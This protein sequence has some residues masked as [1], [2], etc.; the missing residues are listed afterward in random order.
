MTEDLRQV[1]LRVN[2]DGPKI[3]AWSLSG[4]V[5]DGVFLVYAMA[6]DGSIG[7]YRFDTTIGTFVRY[8]KDAAP[9]V[10]PT[11]EPSEPAKTEDPDA[12]AKIQKLE[13]D[14]KSLQEKNREY[15]LD[16]NNV[17]S[18]HSKLSLYFIIILVVLFIVL[19]LA[20]ILAWKLRSLYSRYDFS[21]DDG[22]DDDDDGGD[23]NGGDDG[24]GGS[25]DTDTETEPEKPQEKIVLPKQ[26]PFGVDDSSDK[27]PSQTVDESI[28][29]TVAAAYAARQAEKEAKAKEAAQKAAAAKEAAAKEVAEK[30]AKAK[31]AAQKA[32]AAK[33]AADAAAEKA[34]AA[35]MKLNAVSDK[36][37]LYD[38]DVNT[39]EEKTEKASGNDEANDD[40]FEFIEF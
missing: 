12:A 23:D 11:E 35:G 31:E 25:D 3:N 9:E 18:K 38:L 7:W 29:Q 1:T 40:D 24:N 16:Y 22:D 26:A 10:A 21:E 14:V 36:K 5:S 37:G 33:K 6:E 32:A 13:D 4:D 30:E 2:E 15:A 19:I 20:I 28:K 17:Q 34:K 27:L 8:F 39:G